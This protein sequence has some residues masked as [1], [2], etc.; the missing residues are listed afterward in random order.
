MQAAKAMPKPKAKGVA[1]GK[2]KAAPAPAIVETAIQRRVRLADLAGNRPFLS[3]SK[4]TLFLV[5]ADGRRMILE[6]RT[7]ATPAG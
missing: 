3:K 6:S 4:E 5:D 7:Q 2:A 1:K